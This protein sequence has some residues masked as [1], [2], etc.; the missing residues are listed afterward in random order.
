MKGASANIRRPMSGAW[1]LAAAFALMVIAAFAAYGHL[2]PGGF[3]ADDFDY[4]QTARTYSFSDVISQFLP[5][6]RELSFYRPMGILYW[7]V[8]FRL[9]GIEPTGY[10]VLSILNHALNG[11]LVFLLAGRL[12]GR[13]VAATACGLLFI[14]FP[15]DAEAVGWISCVFDRLCLAFTLAAVYFYTVSRQA[16]GRVRYA[17]SLLLFAAALTSKE[18]ALTLP[19]LLLAIEYFIIRKPGGG[20]R[21][22]AGKLAQFFV[23]LALYLAAREYMFGGIGGYTSGGEAVH[24]AWHLDKLG[25]NILNLLKVFLSPANREAL[26]GISWAS[27][28][29]GAACIFGISAT[30]AAH[31]HKVGRADI[32]PVL[33]GIAWFAV[34]LLPVINLKVNPD[35]LAGTR[36][37]YMPAAGLMI[38]IGVAIT[39]SGVK[40]PVDRLK[41]GLM[42]ILIVAMGMFA[43]LDCGPW[44]TAYRIAAYVPKRIAQLAPEPPRGSHIFIIGDMDNYQGAFLF[45]N[46]LWSALAGQYGPEKRDWFQYVGLIDRYGRYQN[47]IEANLEKMT[48]ETKPLYLFQFDRDKME[49]N[50]IFDPA[51]QDI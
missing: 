43:Y 3:L 44:N 18:M 30:V 31:S 17:A 10:T 35:T 34:S 7:W 22:A 5:I 1:V 50:M 12:T 6:K 45:R 36:L 26:G 14:L 38:A 15:A 25:Q 11:F 48:K 16:G 47:G 41:A 39:P 49:L 23:L 24:T 13:R 40:A 2:L 51:Q 19:L 32:R 27:G 33:F 29:F 4:L 9:F 42:A 46:G 37:Y 28:I 20:L 21:E 8:S